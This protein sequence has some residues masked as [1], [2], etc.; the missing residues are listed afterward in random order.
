MKIY[1]GKIKPGEIFAVHTGAYAGELLLNVKNTG[2]DC[3]FI[4]IPTMVNR[5]I[6]RAATLH[7]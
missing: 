6:P 2:V 5:I 1:S 7:A 4:A 3:C